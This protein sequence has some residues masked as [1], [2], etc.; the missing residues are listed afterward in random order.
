MFGDL[1][2]GG[3]TL[4]DKYR[5]AISKIIGKKLGVDVD[6]KTTQFN[7]IITDIPIPENLSQVFDI[8]NITTKTFMDMQSLRI[9][10]DRAVFF[11]DDFPNEPT[12]IESYTLYNDSRDYL[13]RPGKVNLFFKRPK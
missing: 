3:Y 11:Y 12:G 2:Y 10:F 8:I 1:N 6:I 5:K 4:T 7:I 13:G 9:V